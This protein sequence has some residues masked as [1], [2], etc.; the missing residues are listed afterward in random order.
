MKRGKSISN[1]VRF[2]PLR[3]SSFLVLLS[4]LCLNF[5]Y[6]QCLFRKQHHSWVSLSCPKGRNVSH[7]G[8]GEGDLFKYLL[9]QISKSSSANVVLSELEVFDDT[10][11][12]FDGF[13]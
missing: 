8:E 13:I 11:G 9:G 10:L 4:S 12:E 2:L 3:F 1:N 5:Y 6:F 7:G